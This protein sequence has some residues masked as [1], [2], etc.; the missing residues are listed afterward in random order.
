[1]S[2]R[3]LIRNVNL[4]DPANGHDGPGGVVLYGERIVAVFGGDSAIAAGADVVIV[5]V[6]DAG[7]DDHR[8]SGDPVTVDLEVPVTVSEDAPGPEGEGGG[9][10]DAGRLGGELLRLD[11][12]QRR[13]RTGSVQRACE[14]SRR[15]TGGAR[16]TRPWPRCANTPSG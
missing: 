16:C 1:M 4:F 2:K 13:R 6:T 11:E 15:R 9:L 14:N 3:T 8:W 5:S 10:G 7:N 12:Q